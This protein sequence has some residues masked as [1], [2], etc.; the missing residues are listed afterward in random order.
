V[1]AAGSPPDLGR[2]SDYHERYKLEMKLDSIPALC[3]RFGLTHP[4][5]G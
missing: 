1:A 5:L 4:M 3:E 2:F